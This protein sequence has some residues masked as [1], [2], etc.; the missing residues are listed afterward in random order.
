MSNLWKNLLRWSTSACR[1][2]KDAHCCRLRERVTSNM[3]LTASEAGLLPLPS[4][5]DSKHL[6]IE[7][8]NSVKYLNL[9]Y[10]TLGDNQL[11]SFTN[12]NVTF[13]ACRN[14]CP[15][16]SPRTPP[17]VRW[18]SCLTSPKPPSELPK[19]PAWTTPAWPYSN[20][21]QLWH[22]KRC[23]SGLQRWMRHRSIWAGSFRWRVIRVQWAC[24]ISDH[25]RILLPHHSDYSR[26][27][28]RSDYSRM[29]PGRSS[30]WLWNSFRLSASR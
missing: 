2:E 4:S 22:C 23:H 11:W 14:S 16:N 1:K 13:A 19:T 5:S 20:L 28:R 29:F 26:M 21:H 27:R 17:A 24:P 8:E 7:R 9:S 18:C 6:K 25:S 15:S 30:Y 3:R 10:T 12:T